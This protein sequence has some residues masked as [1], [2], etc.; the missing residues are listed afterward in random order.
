M[1]T[2]ILLSKLFDYQQ[3]ERDSALQRVID[4]VGER[5]T[6][7]ELTGD[8]LGAISAAGDP[9]IHPQKHWKKDDPL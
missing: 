9:Y 1:E 3:F 8:E 7:E 2:D 6:G 5:W 4:E